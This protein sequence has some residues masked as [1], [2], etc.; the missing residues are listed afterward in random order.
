MQKAIKTLERRIE[1][2]RAKQIEL[3]Q[4]E[5]WKIKD[6]SNEDDIVTVSLEIDELRLAIKLLNKYR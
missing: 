5:N 1:L 3:F 2:L 4:K 6:T